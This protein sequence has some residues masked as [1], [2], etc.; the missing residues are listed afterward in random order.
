MEK[1]KARQ[2]DKC[3]QDLPEPKKPIMQDTLGREINLGTALVYLDPVKVIDDRNGIKL[4]F[5]KPVGFQP[6]ILI[7][8]QVDYDY[9]SGPNFEQRWRLC[10]RVLRTKDFQHWTCGNMD[11]IGVYH[12]PEPGLLVI[13]DVKDVV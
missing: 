2:C 9:D 11:F 6:V 1:V 4:T 8:M 7:P 13:G 12:E 5:H 10:C 3:G